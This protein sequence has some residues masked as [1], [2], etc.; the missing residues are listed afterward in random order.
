M[1]HH[2]ESPVSTIIS[3][4]T[5]DDE[6]AFDPFAKAK[7]FRRVTVSKKRN[8]SPVSVTTIT[9]PKVEVCKKRKQ[10]ETPSFTSQFESNT[11]NLDTLAF[12]AEQINSRSKVFKCA[13]PVCVVTHQRFETLLEKHSDRLARIRQC[14]NATA[15]IARDLEQACVV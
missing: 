3:A 9:E 11:S 7:G 8:Q 4:P 1:F 14:F 12:V 10:E 15:A 13:D 6:V 5:S 2:P